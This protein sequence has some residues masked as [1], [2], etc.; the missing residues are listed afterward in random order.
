MIRI[1]SLFSLDFTPCRLS[2]PSNF[3]ST[4]P[5]L[6][7]KTLKMRNSLLAL[8]LLAMTLFGA[9]KKSSEDPSNGKIPVY[10]T[11]RSL[12]GTGTTYYVDPAGND[13]N[14]GTSSATPWQ[15]ISKVNA[16]TFLPGDQILFKAGG[17]WSG[18]LVLAGSGSAGTPITVNMYGT[19]NK[20]VINGGGLVNGSV[21][22]LVSNPYWEVN[23]LEVTNTTSQAYAVTGIKVYN[24]SI[25]A[26]NNHVYVR[27]CYVHDV[28]STG[29]GNTNYNKGTGGIIVSGYFNDVLIDSCHVANSQI[30]GIRTTF[31]N[32]MSTNV[33]FSNNLIENI[34][35]DGIVMSSVQSG[36]LITHN[37]VHNACITNAANFAGIWTYNEN[38]TVVSHNEVYG[39]TGGGPNDGE[40]FDA[41]LTTNGDIFEYNYSHDNNRGFMLFMPSATNIVVRYNLSVN[42]VNPSGGSDKMIN[43]TSTNTTNQIYNNTF[44]FTGSIPQFFEYTNTSSGFAFNSVFNNNIVVGGTVTQFSTQPITAGTFKNNCFYPASLTQTNGPGGTVSGTIYG[45]PVF[46]NSTPGAT[47]NFN[48]Q[49]SSPCINTGTTMTSN[50]G[51]DYYG[52][53]LPSGAPDI[54]FFEHTS[55]LS[56]IG[57]SSIA[58]SYIRDGSYAS[59]NYGTLT[60]AVVKSDVTGYDRKTFEKFDFSSITGTSVHS[61][62]LSFYVNAVNTAPSRTFSIYTTQVENWGETSITWNNAPAATTL[63]GQVVVTKPGTYTLDVTSAINTQLANSDHIISLLLENDGAHSSTND[64]TLN[65]REASANQPQLTISN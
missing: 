22:V 29:V 46:V 55:T 8:S 14:N 18:N 13:S 57:F 17:V 61:A 11:G 36:G 24:S 59:T 30:E 45:N 32:P 9:C 64:A 4:N 54:G 37:T 35:G 65:T 3:T 52:I 20:P 5:I 40:P 28:N 48:L 51:V 19:G 39:I 33:T 1:L 26:A 53:A 25:T 50:G 34:Y 21:T 47:T 44:Y 63:I 38:G 16:Q 43:Y 27:N 56:N 62:T 7:L 10:K 12:A 60:T 58:D 2:K 6:K 31:S 15:T 42:D 41:D 23:N 49:N